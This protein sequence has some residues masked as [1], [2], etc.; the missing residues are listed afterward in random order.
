MAGKEY[1]DLQVKI[2]FLMFPRHWLKLWSFGY[3]G[4]VI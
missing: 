4:A 1:S 3:F 2:V